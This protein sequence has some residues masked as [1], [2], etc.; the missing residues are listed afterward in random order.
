M[1]RKV[2]KYYDELGNLYIKPYKLK[3]LTT[4]FDMNVQTLKS[5]IDEYPEMT[6]TGT[7]YYS[8]V[9]VEFIISKLGLPKK[10][11]LVMDNNEMINA[12]RAA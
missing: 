9:Q 5:R 10:L 8:I 12:R 2:K 4:I 11:M 1:K 3:D 7:Y 6:K